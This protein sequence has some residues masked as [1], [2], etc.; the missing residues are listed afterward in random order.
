A[1][2]RRLLV[3][4]FMELGQILF[5]EFDV[6][7]ILPAIVQ[8][9]HPMIANLRMMRPTQDKQHPTALAIAYQTSPSAHSSTIWQRLAKPL[10][11][12]LS[13]SLRSSRL[14]RARTRTTILRIRDSFLI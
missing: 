14:T 8:P 10:S 3:H 11:E 12:V 4:D 6:P 5:V 9:R 2:I 1:I 13:R 7:I